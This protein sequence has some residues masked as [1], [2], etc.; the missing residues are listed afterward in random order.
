MGDVGSFRTRRS[1]AHRPH[2]QKAVA[3][4]PPRPEEKGRGYLSVAAR[5]L[6]SRTGGELGDGGAR[7]VGAAARHRSSENPGNG[8]QREHAGTGTLVRY[9][10]GG[11]VDDRSAEWREQP[12]VSCRISRPPPRRTTSDA[13][14]RQ[15]STW[16]GQF[17]LGVSMTDGQAPSSLTEVERGREPRWRLTVPATAAGSCGEC[18]I[19]ARA[20]VTIKDPLDREAGAGS[21][22]SAKGSDSRQDVAARSEALRALTSQAC[23]HDV[24]G[25]RS[26]RA[27]RPPGSRRGQGRS[28]AD[29]LHRADHVTVSVGRSE[30][31]LDSRMRRVSRRSWTST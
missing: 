16:V 7:A 15:R 22:P 29:L 14:A 30:R 4:G 20:A 2:P 11:A 8:L 17:G 26:P 10:G 6:R 1:G 28:P 18:P 13:A 21:A 9:D 25:R 12:V 23:R 19:G 5:S 27:G 3:T 24:V 31:K